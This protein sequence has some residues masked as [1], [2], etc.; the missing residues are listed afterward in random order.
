MLSQVTRVGTSKYWLG[1]VTSGYVRLIQVT[2][3]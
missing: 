1:L 3:D 2:P